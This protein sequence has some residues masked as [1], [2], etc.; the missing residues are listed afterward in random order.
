M[1][2]ALE[3]NTRVIRPGKWVPFWSTLG[4]LQLGW[5]VFA[6]RESLRWWEWWEK[7]G[8]ELVDVP[9]DRFD[10]RS[11]RT[12]E[13]SWDEIPSGQV[14]R[15]LIDR[16]EGPHAAPENCHPPRPRR[17]WRASSTRACRSSSRRFFLP[18][19]SRLPSP[20]RTSARHG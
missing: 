18:I 14:V 16:E 19:S 17:N 2:A 5:A 1:C 13:L 3:L 12:R 15:G 20:R 10:E 6:R 11:E 7:K 8:G 9:A 4:G